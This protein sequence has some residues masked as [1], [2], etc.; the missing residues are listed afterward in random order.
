M[1]CWGFLLVICSYLII[2]SVA[3]DDPNDLQECPGGVCV[4]REVCP[5]GKYDETKAQDENI[6]MLRHTGECPAEKVCCKNPTNV[7][8]I[9]KCQS[10]FCVK[11]E[12][13]PNGIYDEIK[14]QKE[15]I[16]VLRFNAN[17][18]CGAGE[19]CCREETCGLSNP[20]GIANGVKVNHTYAKY[21]EYPWV[22]AIVQEDTIRGGGTLIH[23]RFVL[24]AAHIFK[25]G[26]NYVAR[27]GEWDL[28]EE[29]TVLPKQIIDI[30]IILN[31]PHYQEMGY[32]ND[33][34]L[35]YLKQNVQFA[36]HIRPICLPD[37]SDVFDNNRCT[38]V[39]WGKMSPRFD[40][41]NILKRVELPVISRKMCKQQFAATRLGPYFQLHESVLCAGAE[42]GEDT[43]KG[44]G[45]SGLFCSKQSGSYVLAGIVSWGLSCYENN[46]PGAYVDVAKFV[47]WIVSTITAQV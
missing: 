13:C 29:H 10:G 27:F 16:I 30:Q 12:V 20:D 9:K 25:Q 45:G 38:A 31:H 1:H 39:G 11:K 17:V 21:G 6:V 44:D 42:A 43:C 34:A 46:V 8:I 18:V 24:T 40:D 41:A 15:N 14:A 33:I 47:P 35:A 37:V 26:N 32:H 4:R 5:N 28:S 23:P 19:V 3:K 2:S 7:D 22:V 36:K